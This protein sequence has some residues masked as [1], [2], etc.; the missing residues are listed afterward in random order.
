M[1]EFVRCIMK[2]AVICYSV[3]LLLLIGIAALLIF[4]PEILFKILYTVILLACVIAI[5]YL[6]FGLISVALLCF[7]AKKKR[8]QFSKNK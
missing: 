1:N 8:K 7:T 3:V 4:A 2:F 5:I 6:I